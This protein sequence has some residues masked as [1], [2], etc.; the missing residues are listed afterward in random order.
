MRAHVTVLSPEAAMKGPV[1]LKQSTVNDRLF[2][3][4][5]ISQSDR[6][7]EKGRTAIILKATYCTLAAFSMP[8]AIPH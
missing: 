7:F 1:R 8:W 6:A 2:L 3:R 4:E 5:L